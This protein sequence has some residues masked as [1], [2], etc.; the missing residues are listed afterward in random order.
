MINKH[1]EV[2]VGEGRARSLWL[3]ALLRW[4][5]KHNV[6]TLQSPSCNL[7]PASPT[8]N[9]LTPHLTNCC[10]LHVF[11]LLLI[12]CLFLFDVFLF[13]LCCLLRVF[14]FFCDFVWCFFF[15][16]GCLRSSWFFLYIYICVVFSFFILI[17]RFKSCCLMNC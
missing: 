15:L 16:Y 10:L 5:R 17:V 6:L 1:W 9:D 7:N 12:C 3:R 13:F 4:Q 2:T 14:V 8:H 11:L